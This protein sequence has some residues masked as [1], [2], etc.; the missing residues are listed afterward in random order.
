MAEKII[1]FQIEGEILWGRYNESAGK[2]F[3]IEGD[4]FTGYRVS[5]RY[6]NFADVK[7]LA[8]VA[9]EKIICV[10]LNYAKHVTHSQS[11]TKAPE[12]PLL[13]MKP[14]SSLIAHEE[15]IVYPE[16]VDRV[17][18]EAELG[19]IIG[20]TLKKA[21]PDEV[22]GAIFGLTCV[23]DVTARNL[24]KKDGQWTRAKG[25]DTFCPTGPWI[26]RDVDWSD[27]HVEAYL[28]GEQKQSGRT[29]DMIFKPEILISF[30]S[31]VMTL[32]PGDL[33][34]TGTP[35][36]IDPMKVGDKIEVVVENVGRLINYVG[37]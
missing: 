9:P 34:S 10:G 20:K 37:E 29:S 22:R 2:I 8:P 23:N 14:P 17:D 28:N 7:L 30:I 25:F 16:G 24:Q 4:L 27:L 35:E 1:R 36:G 21:T 19:V 18:Y 5:D 26:V 32:K 13:F 15:K 31:K 33:I 12:E 6:Y 3:I 11:A